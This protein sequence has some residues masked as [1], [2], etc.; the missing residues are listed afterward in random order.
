VLDHCFGFVWSRVHVLFLLIA[1]VVLR[2]LLTLRTSVASRCA[3]GFLAMLLFLGLGGRKR[4]LH[5]TL[6]VSGF[7]LRSE[8]F[9]YAWGISDANT[10][11]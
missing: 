3:S 11:E 1:G 4:R 5:F 8:H 9:G 7:V 2:V 6:W 10:I